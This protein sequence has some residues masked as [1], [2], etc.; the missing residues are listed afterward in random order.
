M[1]VTF[2]LIVLLVSYGFLEYFFHLRNLDTVPLRIHV[3]GTRGK[4]SVTRLI[5][6]GLRAG[7]IKTL[8]KTTGTAPRVIIENGSETRI[9]RPGSANIIEQIKFVSKARSRDAKA[10]V[11]ECMALQPELQ[12]LTEHKM[13]RSHIGVITNARADH[14]DVMGET[15]LDVAQ[16]LSNSIPKKGKFFTAETDSKILG[17]FKGVSNR[18]QTKMIT[19]QEDEVSWEKMRGFS[20]IEHR[21]NVALAL[22]V[23]QECGVDRDQALKGM[24][25]AIPDPGVLRIYQ[26]SFFNKDIQFAN[27]FAANDPDS[28]A[29]IWDRMIQTIEPDRKKIVLVNSRGDRIQRSEQMGV[30]IAK[31]LMADAYILVGDYTKIIEDEAIRLGLSEDKIENLGTVSISD[32]FEAVLDCTP[33]RSLVFAIGNIGGMGQSIVDFFKHRGDSGD[34]TSDWVGAR[35]EPYIF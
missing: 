20:Y 3:N 5:A 14:L 17:L 23:C 33:S 25:E 18:R 32:I 28:T 9:F 11:V 12:R 15:V 19:A 26:I 29:L 2:F 34:R 1:V 16:S 6:A 21:E 30:L 10:F 24:T 35:I 27:V 13:I 22:K 8:A 31:R 7:G 4:S